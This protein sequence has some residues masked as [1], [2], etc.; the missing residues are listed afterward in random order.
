MARV[1]D[2][3]VSVL[4]RLPGIGRRSAERIAHR[5]VRDHS[6]T[7]A[8]L[9][10]CLQMAAE[11]LVSCS[12][13]GSI[14]ERDQDPCPLC[15]KP[16]RDDRLLCIVEEP[17][18]IAIIERSGGF[19]GRY[20][21]LQ[22]KLS[23]VTHDHIAPQRL[24]LLLSRIRSKGVNEVLLAMSSD[25]EGD[26]TAA[27]LHEKLGSI[28]LRITRLAFGLPAGSALTYS[29]PVTLARAIRTRQEL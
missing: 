24:E 6:N 19:T 2:Q 23:P 8:E 14:T 25:M 22:G 27:F 16:D 7:L 18:D 12:L 17:G 5:L 4:A 11:R 29:D 9:R 21:C 15:L 26:A 1:F 3:L 20:F 28:P 13:C 10:V